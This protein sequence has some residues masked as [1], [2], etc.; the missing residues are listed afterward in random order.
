MGELI[1]SYLVKLN[2]RLAMTGPNLKTVSYFVSDG[3][4]TSDNPGGG[5]GVTDPVGQIEASVEILEQASHRQSLTGP[6]ARSSSSRDNI[7]SCM[8]SLAPTVT[9][10]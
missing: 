4:P 1:I 10:I 8:A 9:K 2:P 3:V 7:A 5:N 6:R